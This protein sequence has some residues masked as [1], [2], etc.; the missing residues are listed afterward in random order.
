MRISCGI[1]YAPPLCKVCAVCWEGQWL[2]SA[3]QV[4]HT[5]EMDN[6]ASRNNK[7]CVIYKDALLLDT[8]S[9]MAASNHLLRCDF[10]WER[11][12]SW[13]L[14]LDKEL[15]VFSPFADLI[16]WPIWWSQWQNNRKNKVDR[17]FTCNSM[18][19]HSS[20]P[21]RPLFNASVSYTL[22]YNT[23]HTGPHASNS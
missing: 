7:H 17:G 18:D 1:K 19:V 23:I 20:L 15:S 13:C 12:R 22:S 5:T 11:A 2:C 21:T 6:P 14:R 16:T 3:S 4:S 9:Q 8:M 10:L